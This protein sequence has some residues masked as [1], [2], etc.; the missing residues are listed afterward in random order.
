MR[1]CLL[2]LLLLSM[3][4]MNVTKVDAQNKAS[5]NII[6][7]P[8]R[9]TVGDGSMLLENNTQVVFSTQVADKSILLDYLSAQVNQLSGIKIQK[10]ISDKKTSSNS[11]T[12][13]QVSDKNWGKEEYALI[14]DKKGILIEAKSGRGFFYGIQS[15]LQLI[16]L[17]GAAEIP[18]VKILDEPRYQYRGMH[19]D[20]CR[21]FFSVD[22]IKKY[23]DL[24]GTYKM[25]TFHWHLTED[26]GWRIEIKKHPKLTEVGAWRTEKDGSRYGGFYTQEQVKEI[27]A[28]ASERFI[29]VIPEIEL[30]GHSVAALAAYPE[31]ACNEGPFEVENEWGVFDDVYCAGKESTFEFLQD[32]LLE[33]I[34][35]FPSK[36]I[37]IGGDECPKGSWEKC[38]LCQK[39]IKEEGLKDEHEL[40]SYFIQ[41]MEK[42]LLTKD[43]K[44]I[45]WDEI[46]EGGLAPEA[47]V[48]SWRGIKGG[49]E[50]AKQKHD[51]IMTPGTHCYLDH[52][53]DVN[54]I[55]PTAIGGFSPLEKVY[56]FEPTPTELNEDEAKY[57]LGAQGNVWSEY[58]HTSDRVEYM[59]AP[60]IC[61]LAEVVWSRKQQRN[62]SDFKNRMN[63]HYELLHNRDINFFVQAP[64]GGVNKNF[65]FNQMK[66]P[67]EISTENAVIRY[68][69]DGSNPDI[70]SKLYDE[71]IVVSVI[72]TVKTQTFHKSGATSKIRSIECIKIPSFEA[73]AKEELGGSLKYKIIKGKFN[74]VDD[75]TYDE[76]AECGVIDRIG[77]PE[78]IE[79]EFYAVELTG[80][81]M[82]EKNATYTFCNYSI[83]PA[84]FTI[85]DHVL[86]DQEGLNS[87]Y[88]RRAR[89]Y[90]KTGLYPIKMTLIRNTPYAN[91]KLTWWSKDFDQI[92]IDSKILFH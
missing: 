71:P 83:D 21:H 90:L 57:I 42:F 28:Y 89:I 16:P 59:V 84:H 3:Q 19:L 47:T 82:I 77:F 33:V 38:P 26:Q 85:G 13:K 51:V 52:Y 55:E 24:M 58:M 54:Y 60:R 45:G 18:F 61:A 73:E 80:Y 65:F 69:L 74:S 32:V 72:T 30:P 31:L 35:L 15:L 86:M 87:R 27:V 10:K 46:L 56:E 11:I 4:V 44:I 7:K 36:Y 49:I 50:A 75:I 88:Q 9:M 70:Y 29:T 40:Q 48:M 1:T 34:D 92:P 53:Q 67:L 79:E 37:H 91:Q 12:F 25:N 22:F 17:D 39:R 68:T 2:F 76:I 6:P 14:V 43:R 23:I 62:W 78:N 81:I 66:L 20:V 41:R 8:A 5:V 63:Y 64:H